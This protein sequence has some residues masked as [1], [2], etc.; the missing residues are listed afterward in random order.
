MENAELVPHRAQSLVFNHKEHAIAHFW[1]PILGLFGACVS[2]VLRED[3]TQGHY[4]TAQVQEPRGHSLPP[5]LQPVLVLTWPS[6]A[7]L[8]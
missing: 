2:R 6:H 7:W 3:P 8:P 1:E 4:P 5:R